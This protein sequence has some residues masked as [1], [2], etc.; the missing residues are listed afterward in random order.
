MSVPAKSTTDWSTGTLKYQFNPITKFLIGWQWHI[1]F[2]QHHYCNWCLELIALFQF[3]TP[4]WSALICPVE[5]FC[6]PLCFTDLFRYLV[7]TQAVHRFPQHRACSTK[8]FLQHQKQKLLAVSTVMKHASAVSTGSNIL[9]INTYNTPYPL[10][11]IPASTYIRRR[12]IL[13][14][15]EVGS[16][17]LFSFL[18]LFILSAEPLTG[19]KC[20]ILVADESKLMHWIHSV[21]DCALPGVNLAYTHPASHDG[22]AFGRHAA[23]I[24]VRAPHVCC[25]FRRYFKIGAW[26]IIYR[27]FKSCLKLNLSLA[28]V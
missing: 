8:I 5:T 1:T 6:T 9:M 19:S 22:T 2:L 26:Y 18:S 24:V 3:D 10:L 25:P 15:F 7:C 20:A 17:S 27:S 11:L 13:S 12:F 28:N 21:V 23:S 14:L 4:S 16:V